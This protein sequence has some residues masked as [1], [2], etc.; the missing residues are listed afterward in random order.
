M[1]SNSP[2]CPFKV[3]KFDVKDK[4]LQY[5]YYWWSWH[6]NYPHWSKSCW[7]AET[8]EE[9]WKKLN[10]GN[11]TDSLKYYHNKLIREGDGKFVEVADL[12]CEMMD[13]W[14][15]IAKDKKG[16]RKPTD[17]KPKKGWENL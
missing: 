5:H 17:A 9:A 10:S 13:I 12:P 1:N 11:F 16:F 8:K 2:N 6:P 3:P 7:G 14:K 4:T 15:E